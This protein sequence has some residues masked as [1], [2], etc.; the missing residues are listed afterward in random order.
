MQPVQ[1]PGGTV[2][3]YTKRRNNDEYN[4]R[5]TARPPPHLTPQTM[6][7]PQ[8]KPFISFFPSVIVLMNNFFLWHKQ[9]RPGVDPPAN[10]SYPYRWPKPLKCDKLKFVDIVFQQK[11]TFP[12]SWCPNGWEFPRILVLPRVMWPWPTTLLL[13]KFPIRPP[14]Y[15]LPAK[16]EKWPNFTGHSK[17]MRT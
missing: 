12:R 1:P 16:N 4:H 8:D 2:I 14:V 9:L 11:C 10:R 6:S 3:E 17:K 15:P 7:V 13:W 5:P